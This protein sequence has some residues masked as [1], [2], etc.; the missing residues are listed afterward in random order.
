M[1]RAI[2]S[3][4]VDLTPRTYRAADRPRVIIRGWETEE[5]YLV[6]INSKTAYFRGP[7]YVGEMATDA[8]DVLEIK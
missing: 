2:P 1:A 4:P 6:R 8:S 5:I 3:A 7:G